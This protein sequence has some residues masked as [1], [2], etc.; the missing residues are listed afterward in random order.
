MTLRRKAHLR[1]LTASAMTL[2]VW[3]IL[4]WQYV[5]WSPWKSLGWMS[6]EI[7]LALPRPLSPPGLL[8]AFPPLPPGLSPSPGGAPHMLECISLVHILLTQL[9]SMMGWFQSR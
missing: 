9:A 1:D 2:Q 5:D 3:R 6:W 4:P 7:P 8:T